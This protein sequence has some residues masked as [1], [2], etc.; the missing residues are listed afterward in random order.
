MSGD[1]RSTACAITWRR[2]WAAHLFSFR[3]ERPEGLAFVPGQFV[4]LGIAGADGAMVWRAYSI[5]SP[6]AAPHLEFYSIV[7]PDGPFTQPLARAAVGDSIRIDPT[8]YGFLR[9]DRFESGRHLWLLA[10]G[11]GIAPFVSMVEDGSAWRRFERIVV[12]HSV[13]RADEL[14]YRER[15]EALADEPPEGGATL[16]YVPTLTA[17]AARGR[18]TTR[19]ADGGLEAAAGLAIDASQ[20]RLMICGNPSMIRET[21][22]LLGARGMMPVRRETPGHYV[23][24]NFW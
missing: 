13:R 21:R 8:V 4:R 5:V 15:F 16:T 2:D 9:T 6:P 22:A 19:L 23:A 14:A 18:I 7:V 12:V 11:T 3:T 17:E 24:E 20:S 10:T 1:D